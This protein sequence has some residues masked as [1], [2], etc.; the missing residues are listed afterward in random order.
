MSANAPAGPTSAYESSAVALCTRFEAAF[1]P[2]TWRANRAANEYVISVQLY[3][4]H[5]YTTQ[6]RSF[7]WLSV[8]KCMKL[9]LRT[10]NISVMETHRYWHVFS[11]LKAVDR[12]RSCW[13]CMAGLGCGELG[14]TATQL[15]KRWRRRV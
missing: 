1:L 4:A 10:W 14:K 9:I 3:E 7:A 6:K 2:T 5:S 12:S 8:R 11:S 13:N 15:T